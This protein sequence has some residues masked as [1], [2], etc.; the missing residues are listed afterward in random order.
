MG[1]EGEIGKAQRIFKT[2]K[3]FYMILQWWIYVITHLSKPIECT[4]PRV[5]LHGKKQIVFG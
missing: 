2:A 3:L 5:K 1:K 4:P